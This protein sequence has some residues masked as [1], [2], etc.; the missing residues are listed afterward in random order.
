MMYYSFVADANRTRQRN[1]DAAI[2]IIE[3]EI[4]KKRRFSIRNVSKFKGL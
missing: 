4:G 2:S 3:V 1:V